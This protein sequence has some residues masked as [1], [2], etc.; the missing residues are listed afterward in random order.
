MV[1]LTM[2]FALA[3]S[4]VVPLAVLSVFVDER[5]RDIRF[6]RAR[7]IRA[8]LEQRAHMTYVSPV[9]SVGLG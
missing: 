9:Q 5:S 2:A 1:L 8:T 6:T 4:A 7:S 3:V